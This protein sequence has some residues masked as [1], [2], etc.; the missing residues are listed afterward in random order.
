MGV[1]VANSEPTVCLN[2]LLAQGEEGSGVELLS[3]EAVLAS[4][5]N[6]FEALYE[7][8]TA[9]GFAPL[10]PDYLERWLHT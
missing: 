5:F 10:L 4:F 7:L 6:E 3:R 1:N 8:F 9:E 2:D